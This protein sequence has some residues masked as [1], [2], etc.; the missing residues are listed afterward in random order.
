MKKAFFYITGHGLGH[1]TRTIEVINQLC[2]LEPECLPL[3]NT[4]A[5]EWL[6]EREVTG[7]FQYVHCT[8]DVGA[9]QQDWRSVDRPATLKKYAEFMERE[10]EFVK[11]QTDFARREGAGVVVS[12]IPAVAF[13]IAK[14]IGIPSFGITNF[15][16]DWIYAPYLEDYPNYAFVVE[17]LRECYAK[18]SC[19]LRLPFYG[20]LSAFP[21]IEDIPLVARRSAPEREEI[22]RKSNLDPTK[23]IVLIYLGDFDHQ[24][25]ISKEMRARKDLTFITFDALANNGVLPQDL[26]KAVDVVVTKPGYGIVSDCIANRTAILYTDREHFVEYHALVSGIKKYAHNRFAPSAD[27]LSGQWLAQLDELLATTFDWPD[28][29]INGAQIAAEKITGVL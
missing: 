21:K 15:S 9:I 6:F 18:A 14:K 19:L 28:I 24:R 23:K 7:E 4:D 10:P 17:H 2:D 3:I 16:W 26:V 5:P 8:N 11:T 25:V 22:L 12:D 13:A 27:L 29:P 20:D 1:A